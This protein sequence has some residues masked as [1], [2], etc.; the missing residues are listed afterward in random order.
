MG[1]RSSM[2]PNGPAVLSPKLDRQR[3]SSS[4]PSHRSSRQ[5]QPQRFVPGLPGFG[6]S[7]RGAMEDFRTKLL[8]KFTTIKEAMVWCTCEGQIT[9]LE[10]AR[11]LARIFDRLDFKSVG[12]VTLVGFYVIVEA[13]A[14]VRSVEDLRRRWLACRYTMLQAIMIMADNSQ[15]EGGGWGGSGG[16]EDGG[17]PLQAGR[18]MLGDLAAALAVVSPCLLLEDLRDRLQRRYNGDFK[19]A[20]SDLDMDRN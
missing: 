11:A 17:V 5:I 7:S 3:E 16:V 10:L 15:V 20:F 18:I 9:K 19:K 2:T 13:S 14:P 1:R 6:M 4:S 12:R 8:E